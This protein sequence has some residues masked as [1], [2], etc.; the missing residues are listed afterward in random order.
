M[1]CVCAKLLQS[2]L[3]LCDPMDC[4][5]QAPLSM[6]L[7]RQEYWSGLPYLPPG[8]LPNP[9]TEPTYLMSSALAGSFYITKPLGKPTQCLGFK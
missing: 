5:P 7:S 8:H 4:S 3:T 2:C 6:G 1:P 9:E